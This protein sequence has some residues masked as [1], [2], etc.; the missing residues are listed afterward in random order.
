MNDLLLHQPPDQTLHPIQVVARRTGLSADVIRAWERRYQAVAPQRSTTDR[1]L[2]SDE[3][4]ARL[5]LLRRAT[6]AGRRIGDVARLPLPALQ[7]LVV[8]DEAAVQVAPE[9]PPAGE[10][11]E[12]HLA[13]CLQAVQRLDAAALEA[14]LAAAAR[15][16]S[17]PRLLTGLVGGLLERIGDQW[18]L[19][20]LRPCHE[21]LAT[22]QLRLFL[23]GL[24]S[25]ANMADSGPPL[26]VA[27]PTGQ[28]HELGALM[29]AVTAAQSGWR[30]LYLGPDLPS[31]DIAFAAT[32]REVGAVAL[33]LTYPGDDPRLP[34]A[35]R[36][37]RQQLPTATVLL[38]G[39]AAMAG[40]QAV[41]DEIGAW[42]Q[43]TLEEL[44]AM[45]DRLRQPGSHCQ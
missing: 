37:L 26:L 40:Y 32:A 9:P 31:D 21:H 14:A 25:T 19:G 17:I 20:L 43:H 22:T 29:V 7:Q 4:V 28:R 1:R 3:D 36:R 15:T 2:Y 44:Q 16:L 23:G 39:G 41:L 38:V 5:T 35:L 42:Q 45:L 8:V 24:L 18:R 34:A 6:Q 33:S 30:P 11:D 27:T 12:P 13:A 10:H